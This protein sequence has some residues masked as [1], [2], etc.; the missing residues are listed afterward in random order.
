MTQWQS[1]YLLDY[2]FENKCFKYLGTMRLGVRVAGP[3]LLGAGG[4]LQAER[5]CLVFVLI[6]PGVSLLMAMKHEEQT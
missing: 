4:T 3:R 2:N 1:A 5:K 6:Q